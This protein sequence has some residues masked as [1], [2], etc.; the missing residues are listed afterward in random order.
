MSVMTAPARVRS[1]V[2]NLYGFMMEG[3]DADPGAPAVVEAAGPGGEPCVVSYGEL[4]DR[5]DEY[6]AVLGE[7]GLD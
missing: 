6:A 3:A 5:V 1:S 4:R 7:L 2:D